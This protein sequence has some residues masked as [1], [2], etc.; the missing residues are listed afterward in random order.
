[1]RSYFHEYITKMPEKSTQKAIDA[2]IYSDHKAEI[3]AL[4]YNIRD[5]KTK[6]DIL[7]DLVNVWESASHTLQALSKQVSLELELSKLKMRGV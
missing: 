3:D 4:K 5:M 1:M 7:K 2:A 6:S